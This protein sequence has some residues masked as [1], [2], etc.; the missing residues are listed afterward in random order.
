MATFVMFGK[1][2]AQAIKEMSPARTEK[3]V[4]LIKQLGGE[5]KAM[6]ALLGKIDLVFV[7]TLPSLEAALKAS[8][9]LSKQTGIAFTTSPAIS[10][11]EFDKLVA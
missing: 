1:Y 4:A 2:S 9:A 11:E 3:G 6:Y 5:V 10:V 7:V 8:V